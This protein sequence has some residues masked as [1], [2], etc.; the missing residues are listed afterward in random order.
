MV[1]GFA[2]D[3]EH[4]GGVGQLGEWTLGGADRLG[5]GGLVEPAHT[6]FARDVLSYRLSHRPSGRLTMRGLWAVWISLVVSVFFVIGCLSLVFDP[7]EVGDRSSGLFM[8]PVALA[9]LGVSVWRLIR[10]RRS[11]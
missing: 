7:V 5:E 10:H 3:V 11:R 4:E 1:D 6:L 9:G 8:G 2:V